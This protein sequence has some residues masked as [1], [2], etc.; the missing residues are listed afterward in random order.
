MPDYICKIVSAQGTI[1]KRTIT[2]DSMEALR[3]LL[4]EQNE[5]LI[6]AKKMSGTQDLGKY[7]ERFQKVTPKEMNIF[8]NQLKVMFRAGIP[9]IRAL[10]I[11]EKQAAS[12]KLKNVIKDLIEHVNAGE[13]LSASMGRHPTVFNNLF[14]NMIRAGEAAG[15]IDEILKQLQVFTEIDISTRKS[16]KKAIRYPL[17][18]LSVMFVAGGFAVVKVIPT[19]AGMIQARGGELPLLTKALLGFSS[20]LQSSGLL[21][22]GVVAAIIVG[23]RFFLKTAYGELMWDGI[24]L[25]LP[26]AKTVLEVS[27]MARFSL[28]LKTLTSSGV[29]ITDAM[30]IAK[31]TID[32]KVYA[33]TIAAARDKIMEGHSIHEALK[34]DYI[35]DVMINMIAIGEESGALHE[36]L[37]SL[38]DFYSAE[39]E[40]KL[41]DL[42]AAIEPI[43]TLAIGIFVAGFVASIFL[44]MFQ[45]YDL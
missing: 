40:E 39:L 8:T 5:E 34:T 25:K 33:N 4:E 10:E 42:T 16:I 41:E 37:A 14:V 17:I 21:I 26:V 38:G 3:A 31:D 43:A 15:A 28:I 24:K 18:V 29:A 44:P 27:A 2:A 7:F 35:P 45:M 36:M 22:L 1:L 12:N 11:L 6:S 23:L 9:L 13:S 19:F 20:L 30:E 32:N